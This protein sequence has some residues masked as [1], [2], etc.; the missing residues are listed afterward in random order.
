M[1]KSILAWLTLAGCLLIAD[2]V[3][4]GVAREIR[5]DPQTGKI[6]VLYM[7][8]AFGIRNPFPYMKMEPSFI[9]I[10]VAACT[11]HSTM[12][13]IKKQMRVYMPRTQDR[14]S[15]NYD[16]MILSDANREVFQSREINWMSQAVL[17]EGLGII[18]IGGAESY[19]GRGGT[20]P[21]WSITTVAEV[22]P[23]KMLD[24][25]YCDQV[26]RMVIVDHEAELAKSLPWDTLG[27]R[28]VFGEGHKV[29]L[30]Q[31]SHLIAEAETF[32][33]GR[34]PHLIWH[35]AGKGRS[36]SMTTDWTPAGG[37]IF[38]MW[39]YYPDFVLNVVMFT[40]GRKLPEDVDVVYLL[41]RRIR[42][43]VDIRQT[44]NT[45]IDIVDTFGGNFAVVERAAIQCDEE[46][47]AA[48][49]LYFSGEYGPALEAYDSAIGMVSASVEEARMVAKRALLYVYLIEWAVVTGT[50]MISG[51]GL[52]TL[53]IRRKMYAEVVT[54]RLERYQ[55]G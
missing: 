18:M 29:A 53:M 55:D 52:Y 46:R 27:T 26:M 44:L 40:A 5:C 36:F 43:Y 45:M 19:E 51:V 15:G 47:K 12:D 4:D 13:F 14:L 2:G 22:L 31:T 37:A 11:F 35:D 50:F 6:R 20:M 25:E 9:A 39:E 41:R 3:A 54:T 30:K 24:D 17:N 28:A 16:V 42:D 23:V 34:L 33:Y 38:M 32:S 7:G 48:D 8:D 1:E 49:A 10:P 21:T